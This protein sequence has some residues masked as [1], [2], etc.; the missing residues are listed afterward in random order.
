MNRCDSFSRYPG[1]SQ[2]PVPQ[3]CLGIVEQNAIHEYNSQF[4]QVSIHAYQ[5]S[6]CLYLKPSDISKHILEGNNYFNT[7]LKTN[8]M[9]TLT[10]S[11][12][13]KL[14]RYE[15]NDILFQLFSWFQW[16]SFQSARGRY[17]LERN[18]TTVSNCIM[19]TFPTSVGQAAPLWVQAREGRV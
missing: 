3:S 14:I 18:S 2:H 7:H 10:A 8:N 11:E 17:R 9:R 4:C 13:K 12:C 5:F 1:C 19:E 6:K 15:L 16:P